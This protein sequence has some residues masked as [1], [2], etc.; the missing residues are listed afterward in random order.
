MCSNVGDTG[1]P[2]QPES[3]LAARLAVAI[4]ELAAAASSDNDAIADDLA[5]RVAGAWALVT[6]AD[7]E[8]AARTARYSRS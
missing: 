4:E 5:A 2:A 7:P 8:L 3:A 6:A 1:Q